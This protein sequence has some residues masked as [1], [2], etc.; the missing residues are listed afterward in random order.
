LL[1]RRRGL[2]R[3]GIF[4]DYHSA[5]ETFGAWTSLAELPPGQ[6]DHVLVCI[7]SPDS[8]A[9][10]EDI[11]NHP[12]LLGRDTRIVLCQNGWGNAEVFADRFPK[13]RIYN[14]R[15]ITGFSRPEKN[16][17]V[18]TV[19]ADA[20]H[21]GSLFGCDASGLRPLCEAIA[22]GGI[23][24]QVTDSIGKDLWAKM[25]YNCA[26]NP[27]GAILNVPYGQLGEHESTRLVMRGIVTEAFDVMQAAGYQTHWSGADGFLEAFH[28]KMLPLTAAH[29][30]ST[31]QDILAGKTTE[32]EALNGAVIKLAG[33]LNIKVPYNLAVYHM[34]KFIEARHRG[35]IASRQG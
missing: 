2:K 12:S 30:S 16:E 25:L 7:R 13:E 19:H 10:A 35:A 24:C 1:L 23:A 15:V 31:L 5:P 14:A 20:I 6:Y 28:E 29:E 17:V 4:G 18:I 26:L 34:V 22:K 33:R 3:T 32:V 27:L 11:S 9:A 8:A 21:V